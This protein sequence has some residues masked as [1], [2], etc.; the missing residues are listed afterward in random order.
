[1]M[2]KNNKRE[3]RIR[4]NKNQNTQ[5]FTWFDFKLTSMGKDEE[6]L[7]L[8]LKEI[9]TVLALKYQSPNIYLKKRDLLF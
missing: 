3:K 4:K 8:L 7:L 6:E 9:T 1:M 5:R 2:T